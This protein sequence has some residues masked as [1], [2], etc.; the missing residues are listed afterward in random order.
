MTA[1]AVRIGVLQ[2]LLM[3]QHS[4]AFQQLNNGC[5]GIEDSFTLVLRKAVMYDAGFVHIGRQIELVL[6]PGGE[7]IRPV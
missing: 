7:V 6:H 2:L 5:I 3:Q 1:P 4:P